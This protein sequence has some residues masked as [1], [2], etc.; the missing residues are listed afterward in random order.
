MAVKILIGLVV[1]ILLLVIVVATRP[2]SFRVER[3]VVIA[4]PPERL[5]DR[6]NDLSAWAE[7]SPY[8][9]KDPH[10]KRTYGDTTAG[11]GATYAWAGDKNVGE[12]KMTIERSDRPLLV[13]LKLEFFKPFSGTN[14]ATF[15]FSPDAGGTKVTWRMDGHYNFVSKAVCMVMDMDKMI[16]TDFEAGLAT[17]KA[18]AESAERPAAEGAA[19]AAPVQ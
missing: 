19:A 6:V 13:G 1:V 15:A 17:L 4:A 3:S 9:K 14:A 11:V 5:F 12:G 18:Q 2:S 7:W 10:M 8:E 16:G